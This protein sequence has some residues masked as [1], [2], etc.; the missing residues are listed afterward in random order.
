MAESVEPGQPTDYGFVTETK[1]DNF[2]RT[3]VSSSVEPGQP[4]D[5]GLLPKQS[6]T[7][8]REPRSARP[9]MPLEFCHRNWLK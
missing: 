8:S 3:E 1:F 7:T 6:S 9:M 2:T 5:Y 4:T